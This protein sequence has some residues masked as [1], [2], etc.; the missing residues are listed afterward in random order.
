L[1]AA[2][3]LAEANKASVSN[4]DLNNLHSTGRNMFIVNSAPKNGHQVPGYKL[5]NLRHTDYLYQRKSGNAYQSLQALDKQS[6]HHPH[7]KFVLENIVGWAGRFIACPRGLASAWAQRRA[8]PTFF[9]FKQIILRTNLPWHHAPYCP[10]RI[11]FVAIHFS[12]ARTGAPACSVAGST[13][14]HPHICFSS[15]QSKKL[16]YYN[17]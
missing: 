14:A 6:V 15:M 5:H 12:P 8:H 9:D 17:Y 1:L 11:H 13:C 7:G 16:S 3:A 2:I 10:C 4:G